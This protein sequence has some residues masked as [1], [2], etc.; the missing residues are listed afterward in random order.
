MRPKLSPLLCLL[1]LPACAQG[2]K[3]ERPAS[4]VKLSANHHMFGLRGLAGFGAFPVPNTAIFPDRGTLSLIDDATYTITRPT[5]TTSPDYYAMARGG[6]LS[7]YVSGSGR[8]PTVVFKGAYGLVPA[9]AEFCF[10]DR[11]STSSSPS[12]GLYFGTR[13]IIGQAELEGGWHV[14]SLHVVFA[15]S[16][17]DRT[18]ENVGRGVHGGI[19]IS[20]GAPGTQRTISGTGRQSAD[21]GLFRDIAFGGTIQNLL[22][23]AGQGDGTC[24][25]RLDYTT[26]GVTDQRDCFAAAGQDIVLGLDADETDGEAGFVCL[27]RKFD[28]P[29]VPLD[30]TRIGGR[31]LVGGHTLFV[32]PNNSGCDAFIGT[33]TLTSQGAFRLDAVGS[34][35][36]DFAY[37]GSFTIA[38]DGALTITISGTNE[39][40][41]G[42]IDRDYNTFVFLDDFVETR[43]NSSVRELNLGIGVREKT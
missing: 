36:I 29:A 4:E 5:G 43:S 23:N 15:A 12:L 21:S 7:L 26:A 9:N 39:T 33:V 8:D 38:P 2:G 1:L 18:T 17:A 28:P 41:F 30:T 16:T 3:D 19:S 37:S 27:V 40:W 31:F 42:A 6:A 10:T 34:R 35:G 22:D 14:L 11:V 25:L 24:N 13:K 32:N 20:G